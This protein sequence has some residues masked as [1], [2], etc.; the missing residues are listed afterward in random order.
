MAIELVTK[1]IPFGYLVMRRRGRG[2]KCEKEAQEIKRLAEV[3]GYFREE[4]NTQD[5]AEELRFDYSRAA[6]VKSGLVSSK[7][8]DTVIHD[9]KIGRLLHQLG[10]KSFATYSE[11]IDL[12]NWMNMRVFLHSQPTGAEVE[13][14][15]F[16]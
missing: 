12:R 10:H 8:I 11:L 2:D 9:H 15:V 6:I 3:D 14:K 4:R 7:Q 5:F 1:Y 16:F 13:D